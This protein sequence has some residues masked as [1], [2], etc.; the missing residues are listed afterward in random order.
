M[1]TYIFCCQLRQLNKSNNTPPSRSKERT[2]YQNTGSQ[3]CSQT[4]GTRV[5]LQRQ[6]ILEWGLEIYKMSLA[7]FEVP[8]IKKLFKKQTHVTNIHHLEGTQ[9]PIERFP[10][11]KARTI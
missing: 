1:H 2:K 7:H 3:H 10:M 5:F 4:K 9:K 6:L 8:E 11:A